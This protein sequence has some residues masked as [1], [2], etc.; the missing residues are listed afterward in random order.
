MGRGCLA[1]PVVV[2]A[3]ILEPGSAIEGINDSKLLTAGARERI[4]RL[5]LRR[6]VAWGI[7]TS[8]AG[9]IDRI[10]ILKATHLAMK[11][12]VEALVEPPDH[13]LIDALTIPEIPIGQTPLIRGDRRSVSI[14]AASI[15]AKVVRDRVMESYDRRYPGYGFASHRG[16]GTAEHLEALRTLGPS[17]IHRRTFKG[18]WYERMLP[19]GS[20]DTPSRKNVLTGS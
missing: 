4:M 8:N 17:P 11:R 2:T 12:A 18:V 3:V 16:Y 5:I 14:A 1:G 20:G 13:L 10:N 15:V 19:F 9:E 6:A 7:G